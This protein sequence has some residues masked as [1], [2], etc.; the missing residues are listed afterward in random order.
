MRLL[1]PRH[2]ND[3]KFV[4]VFGEDVDRN[5]RTVNGDIDIE[6]N[7]NVTVKGSLSFTIKPEFNY[8]IEWFSLKS[9]KTVVTQEMKVQLSVEAKKEFEML[10]KEYW[11]HTLARFDF[12]IPS[13]PI[14]INIKLDGSVLVD[15]KVGGYITI[16]GE[17]T[18]VSK[19]GFS[20][21]NGVVELIND[22]ETSGGVIGEAKA[23]ISA[24]QYLQLSP[25]VTINEIAGFALDTKIGLSEEISSLSLSTSNL[26]GDTKLFSG[27]VD[28]VGEVK[29]NWVWGKYLKDFT[30]AENF[31]KH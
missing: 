23:T 5:M 14:V 2:Q 29:L 15:V 6:V 3:D 28:A 30:W 17:Y 31:S 8:N 4:I 10:E 19:N 25:T 27:K 20:N 26:D 13:T 11:K 12:I 9:M 16:G 1:P 24:G 21:T 22:V 18:R 7:E